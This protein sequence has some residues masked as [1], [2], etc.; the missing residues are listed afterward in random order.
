MQTLFIFFAPMCICLIFRRYYGNFSEG[1]PTDGRFT[2]KDGNVCSRC[3]HNGN[4]AEGD[5]KIAL[6]SG[7]TFAP[8]N[9]IVHIAAKKD[10]VSVVSVAKSVDSKI[11]ARSIESGEA[12]K[13]KGQIVAGVPHGLGSSKYYD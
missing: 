5:G 2:F 8:S 1:A 12:G 13:Y 10:D 9:D 7:K 3:D 6:P 11:S 4:F